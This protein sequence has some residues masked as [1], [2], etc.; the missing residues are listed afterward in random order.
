MEHEKLLTCDQPR[1]SVIIAARNNSLYLSRTIESVLNQSIP[2]EVIYS[3]DCSTDDSVAI[4]RGFEP[5]GLVVLT[6]PYHRGVC[7]TRNRG[8]LVAKGQYLVFL[9]GDD[10]LS[11]DF[12][13]QHLKSV[14]AGTPFVY[15]PAHAFGKGQHAGT[16]W[17]VP[18]WDDYDLWRCNTVNTSAM[19]ARWAFE[20]AGRWRDCVRSMWDWDLA[21]R[22]SR[23]GQPKPSR[24]VLYY[25]MHSG[26]WSSLIGEREAE[27]RAEQCS[28]V[29]RWN[30]RVSIGAILSGRLPGLFPRW[31]AALAQ[32]VR[33]MKL[34][35]KPEL[36][37]LDNS[38][39]ASIRSKFLVEADKYCDTF[40]TIRI[41]P[42]PERF[43]WRKEQERRDKVAQFMASASNR[44]RSE[45]H[46]DIHWIVEDD[47][48]VP[49]AAGEQLWQTLTAG[50][51]PLNAVAGCYR[52]R[53]LPET[54]VGGW[55][56]NGSPRELRDLPPGN[57]PVEVDFTGTG[58]L[59]YWKDRTPKMWNSHYQG[60]PAHDWEWCM[61]VKAA[62]GRVAMLPQVRCGHAVDEKNII[63]G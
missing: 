12:I 2:A 44:L 48:L 37:Y 60:V 30:A 41:L 56:N 57:V 46:G 61:A 52:N 9:D 43:T 27:Q 18:N 20:A 35:T 19:Y 53:H 10:L 28:I 54:Y 14:Q 23:F 47:V 39:K 49:L 40:E 31:M 1:V 33:L 32:S 16:F 11:S 8:A 21:I 13:E 6:S 22:A 45:M 38:R 26:S 3:D 62:K 34:S 24:A 51:N 7:E 50:T 5:R 42:F 63:P 29:R 15:G 59:M 55:W 17:D 4:A 25:R 58:C 36:V